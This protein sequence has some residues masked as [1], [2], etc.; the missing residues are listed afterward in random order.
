[1]TN[2]VS[3]SKDAV[4]VLNSPFSYTNINSFNLEII[5]HSEDVDDL[6]MNLDFDI[7]TGEWIQGETNNMVLVISTES[8]PNN[9][10][11]RQ[12]KTL[13]PTCTF[14]NLL[15]QH[16]FH[17]VNNQHVV[18]SQ[19]FVNSNKSITI[20]IKNISPH[21][22]SLTRVVSP[23]L[24]SISFEDSQVDVDL[25]NRIDTISTKYQ[26][27]SVS[28]STIISKKGKISSEV[29]LS[30]HEARKQLSLSDISIGL[31]VLGGRPTAINF[32]IDLTKFPSFI[33]SKETV[34]QLV[35]L[36][37]KTR[38]LWG[39]QDIDEKIANCRLTL[40]SNS[41]EL[42]IED[43]AVELTDREYLKPGHD[44]SITLPD[45]LQLNYY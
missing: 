29:S 44:Y 10:L 1:M 9:L 3:I 5:R 26:S 16:R 13:T 41:S 34:S 43:I 38:E 4:R 36:T 17:T 11:L 23:P 22:Y 39:N 28:S 37:I 2:S 33:T 35:E 12:E 20:T 21:K 25:L 32:S 40:Y 15:N 18:V 31:R 14:L 8:V 30:R 45:T 7:L 42:L 27:T 19:P 24:K 6:S